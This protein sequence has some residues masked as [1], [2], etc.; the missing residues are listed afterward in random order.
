M[1][2][3]L[4]VISVALLMTS[5]T[6]T[7]LPNTSTDQ[8]ECQD[9]HVLLTIRSSSTPD[10]C[11]NG[12]VAVGPLGADIYKC[13]LEE[14]DNRYGSTA[15]SPA[16]C[17]A[18]C[19][20]FTSCKAFSWAP[21]NGD[22][23][24]AGQRV[25][26]I[27]DA[28]WSGD[29]WP[30][31]SG[32]YEQFMC[33]IATTTTTTTATT[34]TTT[35]M[36]GD[37]TCINICAESVHGYEHMCGRGYC[38]ACHACSQQPEVPGDGTCINICAESVHG[39]EHMCGRGYCSAC[40]ACSQQPKVPGNGTCMNICAESIHGYEHMCGRESCSACPAC[41]PKTTL[42][43]TTQ[44]YN[45]SMGPSACQAEFG[46]KWKK[47]DGE[48]VDQSELDK[49]GR[50]AMTVSGAAGNGLRGGN[51]GNTGSAD[52]GNGI[53]NHAGTYNG[54]PFYR[55][56]GTGTVWEQG[57]IVWE[58]GNGDKNKNDWGVEH[59]GS[60]GT[61]KWTLV[62]RHS[63]RYYTESDSAL[64]PESSWIARDGC[65]SD[66]ISISKPVVCVSI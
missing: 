45:S 34:T 15:D 66:T 52:C 46:E 12:F 43:L 18:H 1:A 33:E 58:T 61:A 37:G 31:I 36:P 10:R 29:M 9:H 23:Y 32:H 3:S 49:V 39:Y 19:K 38:S 26:T 40:H 44:H 2:Q 7:C 14:C 63:H 51:C 21:L 11:P 22:K 42:Q 6:C 62:C 17:G 35:T 13:G 64:P 28:T 47:W 56:S 20:S 24:H 27:Y 41:S 65:A 8:D 4:A 55:S 25:C 60:N 48:A 16:A 53:W 5:T 30:G 54:K 59:L 57:E 50:A